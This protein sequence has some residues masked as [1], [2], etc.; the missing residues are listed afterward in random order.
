TKKTNA[1][2]NNP[3]LP[4]PENSISSEGADINL[5]EE[6]FNDEFL[7][8]NIEAV[9]MELENELAI[10]QFFDIR[11]LERNQ[12]NI[13]EEGLVNSQRPTSNTND[14]WSVNNIMLC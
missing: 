13:T 6:E 9:N 10:N 8:I 11:M 4:L 7:Q 5:F 2:T 12:M 1:K 3:S 14:D